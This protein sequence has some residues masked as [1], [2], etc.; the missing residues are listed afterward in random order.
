MP[1]L[2]KNRGLRGLREKTVTMQ[3]RYALRNWYG[4]GRVVVSCS[5]EFSGVSWTGK[6]WL[7]RKSLNYIIS[8]P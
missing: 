4:H 1:H 3:T 2:G 5:A 8:E 7:D 6:W